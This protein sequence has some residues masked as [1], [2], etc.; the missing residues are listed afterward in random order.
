MTDID[1]VVEVAHRVSVLYKMVVTEAQ[2]GQY[3]GV[4]RLRD[5]LRNSIETRLLN[6]NGGLN[7]MTDFPYS[8]PR[9]L[10]PR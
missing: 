2:P 1:Y 10:D 8:I 4:Q 7:V 6:E 5:G 3:Y 9:V